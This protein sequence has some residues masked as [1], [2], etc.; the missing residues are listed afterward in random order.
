MSR[1][2][3]SQ[4]SAWDQLEELAV[5]GDQRQQQQKHAVASA[6]AQSAVAE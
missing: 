1:Q 5:L 3:Q 2:Q 6:A 4:V